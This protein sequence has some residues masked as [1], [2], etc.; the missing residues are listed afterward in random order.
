MEHIR[1]N[2]KNPSLSLNYQHPSFRVFFKPEPRNLMLGKWWPKQKIQDFGAQQT[3]W[4][5]VSPN[6]QTGSLSEPA[7]VEKKK[8]K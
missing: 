4:R 1:C 8:K 3:Q 5:P 7:A 2:G 6:R